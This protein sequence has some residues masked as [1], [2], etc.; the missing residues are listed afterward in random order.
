MKIFF[1]GSSL[2]MT[3]VQAIEAFQAA[4]LK[5]LKTKTLESKAFMKKSLDTVQAL[6]AQLLE[7]DQEADR[8]RK[9][10]LEQAVKLED[11]IHKLHKQDLYPDLYRDSESHF[12][13]MTDIIN[14]FKTALVTKGR[15]TP[16]IELSSTVR[17]WKDH[18]VIA[19][20]RDV[21]NNMYESKFENCW[22]ALEWYEKSKTSLTYTFEILSITGNLGD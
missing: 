9:S 6:K 11:N 20:C 22:D 4:H 13:L 16:I 21:K 14:S 2:L 8:I 7:P 10:F 3:T 15:S 17:P 5:H 12:M 19:F 18:G 1:N